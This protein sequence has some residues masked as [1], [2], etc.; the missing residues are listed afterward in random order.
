[1]ENKHHKILIFTLLLIFF[2]SI[3][4]VNAAPKTKPGI[5]VLA[6]SNFEII[7]NKNV[8]L[9]TNH[10][11]RNSDGVLTVEIFQKATECKLIG[12]LVPEHGFYTTI[13]AGD[14]VK[15][16]FIMGVPAY[17]LYGK[18]KK[19]VFDQLKDCDVVVVDIQDIGVRS[20][21]YISTMY[22]TMI[23]CADYNIPIVIL[24]RPNPLGGLVTDGN[25][26][27]VK[28][29]SFVGIIPVS[30][31]HGC[32]IAELAQ[33]INN[34]DWLGKDNNNKIRKCDLQVVKMQN[35]ERWM[36]WEDTGLIWYPTSPHIPT[37]NS[38]RGIATLGIFG[39]LGIISIG[40]GTSS[41]FQYIGS[42]DFNTNKVAE[43]LGTLNYDGLILNPVKYRPFYGMYSGKDCNGFLLTFPINPL[44]TP[45]STGIKILSYIKLTKPDLFSP[46]KLSSKQQEMFKKVTGTDKILNALKYSSNPDEIEKIALDGLE[47]FIELR[48]KYLLY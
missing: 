9:L 30:Y 29:K 36:V 16:E 15:D 19:P 27:D 12:L 28:Y 3:Q 32:T 4:I 17:S 43:L 2:Y 48:K 7:R 14:N 24:D 1:M 26:L 8:L 38:I 13:P 44:F 37:V 46:E 25:V 34:E 42:P 23:A 18:N 39:E 35:W 31:I 6:D 22:N 45:Y 33:M 10:A 47:N 41:P 20:Y 5:D 11:G 21:T 40:I